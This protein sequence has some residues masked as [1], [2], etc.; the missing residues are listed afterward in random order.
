MLTR[1]LQLYENWRPVGECKRPIDKAESTVNSDVVSIEESIESRIEML[2]RENEDIKSDFC[3]Y[4]FMKELPQEAQ[5]GFLRK[6]YLLQIAKRR[7]RFWDEALIFL[8]DTM[9][10]MNM[11]SKPDCDRCR[12]LCKELEAHS[13]RIQELEAENEAYWDV[14]GDMS[15][16]MLRNCDYCGRKF[17]Q[18]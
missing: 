9:R 3:L 14:M 6:S 11:Y 15:A 18:S 16:S 17:G 13:N 4:S 2:L 8:N 10:Y 1:M 7:Q 5:L 12:T